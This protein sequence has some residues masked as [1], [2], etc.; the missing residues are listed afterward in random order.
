MPK[1]N[2]RH[3]RSPKNLTVNDVFPDWKTGAADVDTGGIFYYLAPLHVPWETYTTENGLTTNSITWQLDIAYH[4]TQSGQKF[5]SPIVYNYLDSDGEL[6]A[7]DASYLAAALAY[8]YKPKWQHLWDLYH[9]EY[10]PMENYR[11]ED[12]GSDV[13]EEEGESSRTRTPNLA[14]T[15]THPIKTVQTDSERTPDLTEAVSAEESVGTTYDGT[16]ET[17]HGHVV[18]TQEAGTDNVSNSRFGFNSAEA[19]PTDNSAE[20]KSNSKTEAHSGKDTTEDDSTE[21]VSKES[22]QTKTTSG[23]DTNSTTEV[24][25]FT[26]I[27]TV[28]D[29]GTETNDDESSSTKTVTYGRVKSG[30]M[31]Q[32]PAAIMEADRAFWLDDYFAIVFDDVDAFLTLDIYSEKKIHH[33]VYTD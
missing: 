20:T 11:M 9:S 19:V 14:K 1:L 31:Y 16:S 8:R 21:N 22:S 25:S 24:E 18:G 13:I 27:D 30:I 17:T 26:G 5:I 15:T 12:S 3:R 10:N 4:G 2:P 28:V 23:T 7:Q 33:K 6:S 29:T 32:N